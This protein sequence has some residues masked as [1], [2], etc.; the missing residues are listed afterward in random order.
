LSEGYSGHDGAV[1]EI[2]ADPVARTFQE[3]IE[4]TRGIHRKLRISGFLAPN[5]EFMRSLLE[6]DPAVSEAL[7]EQVIGE[8]CD[9]MNEVS[10][11]R[12][13]DRLSDWYG[14]HSAMVPTA[15]EIPT[16]A[17]A[18]QKLPGSGEPDLPP[19]LSGDDADGMIQAILETE[20]VDQLADR[21][22]PLD[23]EAV[24]SILNKLIQGDF[25]VPLE[26][27]TETS[28]EDLRSKIEQRAFDLKRRLAGGTAV[29]QNGEGA[30]SDSGAARDQL[31][32]MNRE[33]LEQLLLSPVSPNTLAE[34]YYPP[35]FCSHVM[36]L[37]IPD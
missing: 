22:E 29:I 27:G 1:G 21:L 26:E 15:I 3:A 11:T 2:I 35:A 8:L 18:E 20:D 19:F 9:I 4:Q 16:G 6:S 5:P 33:A 31:H 23:P 36:G 12:R 13:L 37:L 17:S 25:D 28:E 32:E 10:D 14:R 30:G 7:G 24:A 34:D